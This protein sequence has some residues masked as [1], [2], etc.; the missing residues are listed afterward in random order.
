MIVKIKEEKQNSL[1]CDYL[2]YPQVLN[3][4]YDNKYIIVYQ[5]YDGSEYYYIYPRAE[6]RDSLLSQFE[7]VKKTKTAIGLST[8]RRIGL[9]GL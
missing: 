7:K 9:W 4:D 6:K 3:F 1:S 8:R 5:V 2:I